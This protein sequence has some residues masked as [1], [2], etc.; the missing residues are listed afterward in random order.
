MWKRVA[1]A[2]AVAGLAGCSKTKAAS[3]ADR[4]ATVTDDMVKTADRYVELFDRLAGDF[5]AAGTDC[6][7]AAAAVGA[8]SAEAEAM[9]PDIER[10]AKIDD[11]AG[12]TWFDTN[13]SPK[14]QASVERFRP[15]MEACHDDAALGAAMEAS[16]LIP[17]KKRAH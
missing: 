9:R 8:R 13:Y 14:M 5:Q 16:I 12:K 6:A 3:G 15:I 7:K 4:P 11:A 1:I 2:A 10:L 17:R